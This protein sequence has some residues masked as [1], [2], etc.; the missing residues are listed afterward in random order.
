MG[1]AKIS[2]DEYDLSPLV[3]F[4]IGFLNL[5]K[6]R[7][8]LLHVVSIIE[9]SFSRGS[10]EE[11]AHVPPCLHNKRILRRSDFAAKLRGY[12]VL[13]K[14]SLYSGAHVSIFAFEI[15]VWL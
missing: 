7:S 1:D 15:K 11:S 9:S 3:G 8:Y 14:I 2:H 10:T 6:K 13:D 5:N 4:M 12:F